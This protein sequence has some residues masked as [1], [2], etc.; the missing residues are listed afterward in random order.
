M[1]IGEQPAAVMGFTVARGKIVAIDAV[2]APEHLL[3]LGL[4]ALDDWR[5]RPPQAEI[6]AP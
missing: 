6:P 4:T 3:R 5:P 2:A 1:T